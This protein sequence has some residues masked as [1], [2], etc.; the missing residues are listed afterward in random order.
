MPYDGI[1]AD[2]VDST[3]FVLGLSFIWI[4]CDIF[5][6]VSSSQL[7]NK[8]KLN[9]DL[10]NSLIS[11]HNRIMINTY[12]FSAAFITCGLTHVSNV[13]IFVFEI[14]LLTFCGLLSCDLVVALSSCQ[15]QRNIPL[16]IMDISCRPY[17]QYDHCT[18]HRDNVLLKRWGVVAS[19]EYLRSVTRR[20]TAKC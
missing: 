2:V 11:V 1:E 12:L 14:Y 6:L 20:K 15:H 17:H 10:G 3:E 8:L 9:P 19:N 16:H 5:R 13:H 7:V 18:G 4:G